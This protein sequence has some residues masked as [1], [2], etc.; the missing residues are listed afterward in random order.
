MTTL[1]KFQDLQKFNMKKQRDANEKAKQKVGYKV[2][3]KL[4]V[5][6]NIVFSS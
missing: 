3:L 1:N 2:R 6:L 4:F 5:F